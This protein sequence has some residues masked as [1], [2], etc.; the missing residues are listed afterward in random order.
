MNIAAG[1]LEVSGRGHEAGEVRGCPWRRYG[2]SWALTD[3]RC[4]DR[5]EKFERSIQG[6]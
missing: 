5:R 1:Q 4:G 6:N 2:V 3:M